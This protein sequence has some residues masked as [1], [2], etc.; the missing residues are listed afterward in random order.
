[1]PVK[2]VL[3]VFGT[4]PEAIKLAP[5]IG[6]IQASPDLRSRVLVTAQHRE[7]LDQPLAQFGIQP[8]IDLNLMRP[9]QTLAE[10]TAR[11]V[12]GVDRVLQTERPDLVLVQGDTT[13]VL[14]AGLAAFYRGV[15][16]GHVE[17][18][19]R[20]FDLANPFP[21]EANRKLVAQLTAL[22]FAPTPRAERNLLAEGVPPARVVVTGNTG[23][24]ALQAALSRPD[25]PPPPASWAELPPGATRVLVTLHR[26]ESWG[27]PL[28]GICRALRQAVD[29]LPSLHVV[30]PVHPQPRVRS[31][32]AAELAGHPRIALIE[33]LDY[34]HMVAALRDCSFIASDS[35]GLQEEAPAVGKPVLVLREV[36]ERPEA[37]EAGT[38]W[39][40]GTHRQHV[41]EALI[42]LAT[43]RARYVRMAQARN[44]FGDGHAAERIVDAIRHHFGL[45]P[46]P[47]RA[48]VPTGV[49]ELPTHEVR[50]Q[51]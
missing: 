37:V 4:R 6:A 12:Q 46:D 16:L 7:L 19:L 50:Q 21:E 27:Q 43:D 38:N 20:S 2:T 8:D 44:P 3:S 24:D 17:A 51:N 15:P 33:P 10:L 29:A 49:A 40:V 26:R 25:L 22:H 5:V 32:V 28:A 18:G 42:R 13:T 34:L 31:T 1:M 48:F 47:P 14:A 39:L 23:I 30:Y 45:T 11:V 36:T 41:Y 35:G 9:G